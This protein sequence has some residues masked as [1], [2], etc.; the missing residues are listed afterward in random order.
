VRRTAL[1]PSTL[2]EPS[3]IFPSIV[4]IGYSSFDNKVILAKTSLCFEE[5]NSCKNAISNN[6][7]LLNI[8]FYIIISSHQFYNL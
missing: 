5:N 6:G 7:F 2:I 8:L 3:V 1:A 4:S